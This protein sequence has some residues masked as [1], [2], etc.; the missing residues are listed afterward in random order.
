ME[1]LTIIGGAFIAWLILV[2]ALHAAH[3]L[4]H[5][6]GR[7][8]RRS[9]HFIHVLESICHT[10]LEHGNRIE[11]LTNGDV[12]YPAMLEAIRGARETVNLECYIFKKGE[13]GDQFIE[14]LCRA[15][16]GRRARD[17]RDGRDRQLRR[18]PRDGAARLRER[19]LPR[20]AYQPI[21]WYRW[22]A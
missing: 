12:F 6:S 7:S 15:G 18:L 20:R 17:D 21:T 11:I 14:A 4:S 8:T 10:N 9:D 19:R 1:Y 3:P 16:A 22:P 5:R 2:V 13:I